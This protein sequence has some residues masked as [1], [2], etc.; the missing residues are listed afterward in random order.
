M[1][2]G[3]DVDGVLFDTEKFQFDYGIPFFKEKYNNDVEN[4][5]GYGIKEVF[6]CSQN[7]ELLFWFK[8]LRK[9]IHSFEAREGASLITNKLHEDGDKISIITSR[10][11]TTKVNPLG[12]IMRDYL[13]HQLKRSDIYYDDI[14]F[15]PN[16]T[17]PLEKAKACKEN[18][19]DIYIEDRMDNIDHIREII[20]TICFST[21]YNSDYNSVL[22][23][24]SFEEIYE[25]INFEKQK[26][27]KRV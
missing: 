1:N 26:I 25:I 21:N 15:C 16:K 27:R 8:H 17:S 14:T 7:K 9:Y 6:N 12:I 22:R 18:K 4:E 13:K 11:C 3:F 5:N 2:I 24:N 10:S 20:P 23:V 19:I